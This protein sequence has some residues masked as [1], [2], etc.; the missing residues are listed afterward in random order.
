MK[1]IF[2]KFLRNLNPET[3][4][5][6]S[7]LSLKYLSL[8]LEKTYKNEILNSEFDT[9]TFEN[10]I[11]LAAGYDKNAEVINSLFKMG[12]GFVECGT[13]TPEPQ[14]GN[15]KPRIF[16][17][18]EDKGI[19]NRLGFNNCGIKQF[20]KNFNQRNLNLG[21]VGVNIGPNKNSKNLIDDYLDLFNSVY[22]Y[23]DYITLN[24]SSPNTKNL[25]NI[26]KTEDLSDLTYEINALRES[27]NNH[28]KIVLK[29]DPDSSEEDYSKII[30]IVQKNKIDGLIVSNTS[31]FRPELLKSNFRNEEGGLSGAPIKEQSNKVLKF[32]SKETQGEVTLIGVGGIGSAKDAYEKIKLGASLVQIYSSLTFNNLGFIN[33]INKELSSYVK[34]D[35]FTNVKEAIGIETR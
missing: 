15:P 11:G 20:M 17:L 18:K 33:Q 29:I 13:V 24:V 30:N 23:A 28:K 26:Q 32:V 21:I 34:N 10:P 7:I 19:I 14:Y 6:I 4:H 2:L 9:L 5:H 22:E 16:R 8:F 3:S 31:I 27:K 1:N 12:F 35:G 25:R